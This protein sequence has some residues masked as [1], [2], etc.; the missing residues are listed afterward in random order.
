MLD[1]A[2][3]SLARHGYAGT[4]MRGIAA[5]V[6]VQPSSL[7]YFFRSKDELFEAVYEL[8]MEKILVAV[9]QSISKADKPWDRLERAA[10]A[11]LEVLLE[12]GDYNTLVANIVPRGD[13]ELDQR[14]IRHRDR[15]EVL[16]TGLIKDLPLPP[17]TDRKVFRLTF[18]SALNGV[19]SWYRR[20]DMSPKKIAAKIVALFRKQ[21]DPDGGAVS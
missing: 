21:L 16:F 1:S 7:Y 18:L 19:A 15:Y 6:G 9:E 8:G 13:S 2:A 20:G 17:R 5:D 12:D 10:I 4:S 3:R 14:L 11:H